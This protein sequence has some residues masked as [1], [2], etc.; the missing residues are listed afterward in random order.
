[1]VLQALE[2]I[3]YLD[4]GGRFIYNNVTEKVAWYRDSPTPFVYSIDLGT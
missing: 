4:V 3:A 2:L 1:M